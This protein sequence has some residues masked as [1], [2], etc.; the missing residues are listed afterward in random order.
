MSYVVQHDGVINGNIDIQSN[1][2]LI[3][4]NTSN[5]QNVSIKVPSGLSSTYA[6]TLP[7]TVAA[8]G[9]ML[10]DVAGNGTLTWATPP[11]TDAAGTS[12]AVQFAN[13]TSFNG[14]SDFTWDGTS[15]Q[16]GDAKN[17]TAGY[18]DELVITHSGSAGDGSIT[19]SVGTF[20]IENTASTSG[21]VYIKSGLDTAS[22][23]VETRD[24]SNNSLLRVNG[25]GQVL[26]GLGGKGYLKCYD[27]RPF[28]LGNGSDLTFVHDGANTTM[29]SATGDLIFDN[30]DVA[31]T[32]AFKLGT[33]TVDTGFTIQNNTG[34]QSL[35]FDGAGLITATGTINANTL[36]DGTASFTGGAGTGV[37]TLAM[38]GNL[39]M[40]NNVALI[41]HTGS[42]SL[43]IVSSSGFVEV[44]NSVF[45]GTEITGVTR[46]GGL[47][48]PVG[49]TDAASKAYVDSIA[50]Q[51]VSW[52]QSVSYASASAENFALSGAVDSLTIDGTA[53][54]TL[55]NNSRVLLKNQTLTSENA[56]YT[57]TIPGTGGAG[58]VDFT[59]PVDI[60]GAKASGAAVF[61]ENGTTNDNQGFV[62]TDVTGTDSFG[63]ATTIVWGQ[64]TSSVTVAPGGSTAV[65]FATGTSFTG[66]SDFTWDGTTLQLGDAKNF[67]VGAGDELVITH[68]GAAGSITNS[69]GDFT[70]ENTLV[71][72]S[73]IVKLGTDTTATDFQIQNFSGISKF[74]VDAVGDVSIAS[75]TTSTDTT[76]GALTVSGGVG[77]SENINVGGYATVNNLN[78]T[79]KGSVTQI[80][81]ITT[82]VTLNT[83]AGKITTFDLGT[84]E[85][86]ERSSFVVNNTNCL[87]TSIVMC[88]LVDFS[89]TN[90]RYL[91]CGIDNIAENQFEIVLMN[92]S[93]YTLDGTVT[94]AFMII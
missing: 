84:I 45:S 81:S 43:S 63:S 20:T 77:I 78:V 54:S 26:V 37:S 72:G 6:L 24:A 47:S 50:G 11:A 85:S 61:V 14:S 25:A 38:T 56:I 5:D 90:N 89:G 3:L 34:S 93:G 68:S 82:G 36:T 52:K 51:G 70:I 18:G 30:T 46:V 49:N 67:T 62:V 28:H 94:L 92:S 69:V 71:T 8:S 13:G 7:P 64:F 88:N 42:T 21:H 1:N 32:I 86:H 23:W 83:Y 39:S 91:H 80:T 9:Q 55:A 41:T 4:Q 87:S 12:T 59:L 73:T 27:N 60:S 75:A 10:T 79:D 33:D 66:S 57:V 65:Q 35:T 2:S 44:E 16:L 76:S 53:L 58:F 22:S 17:F 19:N 48:I 40:S 29:T 74:T 31:G 15:L